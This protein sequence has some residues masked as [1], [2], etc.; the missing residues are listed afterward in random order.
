MSRPTETQQRRRR[1]RRDA[2]LR[3]ACVVT[4]VIAGIAAALPTGFALDPLIALGVAAIAA[5]SASFLPVT[6]ARV[7]ALAAVGLLAA[8]VT[9]LRLDRAPP[10]DLSSQL[11]DVH[12]D[13]IVTVRGRVTPNPAP[14]AFEPG[15]LDGFLFGTQ[16]QSFEL[17]A[18]GL[19]TDR[20]DR[21]SRGR[22]RITVELDADRLPA[23]GERIEATGRYVP[24][25]EPAN[26]GQRDLGAQQRGR[27]FAGTLASSSDLITPRPTD[28]AASRAGR[29]VAGFIEMARERVRG[30]L[31]GE[32]VESAAPGR[33]ALAA[34]VLGE[35]SAEL[36]E[37]RTAFAES[38]VAH[39]LA[40]SGFHLAALAWA[41]LGVLRLT[42]DLGRAAPL[43]TAAL[44]AGYLLIVPANAPI[45]RAGIVTIT[46]LLADA[47]GR[48]YDALTLLL[49][50]AAGIALWRPWEILTLGY[51]LTFLV[52]AALIVWATSSP[53]AV[54]A[55]RDSDH[56]AR[57][58]WLQLARSLRRASE[59]C[60]VAWLVAASLVVLHI[61][62]LNPL[63]P[64][65]ALVV[66]PIAGAA[67]A[68]GFAA[69]LIG[70]ALP[71][72]GDA[73]ASIAGSAGAVTL[74]TVDLAGSLGT[75]ASVGSIGLP[76][77]ATA[78][79][80]MFTALVARRWSQ[81]VSLVALAALVTL[82][83]VA[84]EHGR[85][86]R[87]SLRMD[88]L[89]VG[90][91]TSV[92]LRSGN[93][94]LLWDCGS[95]RP[96][97][98]RWIVPRAAREFGSPVITTAVLTHANVDHFAGL[99]QAAPQIGLERLICSPHTLA[100]LRASSSGRVLLDELD[101]IG[102]E[103]ET[104]V[105][106]DLITLGDARGDVLWPPAD[107]P[108]RT[109]AAN[110]RSLVVR[111]EVPTSAGVRT[112]LMTGDIQQAAMANL[113][114]RGAKLEA[115]VL[116]LPHHGSYHA[117][118]DAFV[119]AVSPR[120]VAQSTGPRRLDL[121]GWRDDIEA[122][123]GDASRA[124]LVT[125]RDGAVTVDIDRDGSIRARGYRG[126]SGGAAR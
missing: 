93:D 42:A 46:L 82:L 2:R 60:V 88:M 89:A 126:R 68:A 101:A 49:W 111:F 45:V 17:A 62:A 20:G 19:V 70:L 31:L 26:P 109:L 7:A 44:I 97:V 86:E 67:T 123:D 105:A 113:F 116:E 107:L 74:T 69:G 106:G 3:V 23:V 1:V 25:S 108:S 78:T 41:A 100:A 13:A 66:T 22:L 36:D 29:R 57:P 98:G 16:T 11:A 30:T 35:R 64:L 92:L 27:R 125:A 79:L 10:N 43:I 117:A 72:L 85:G 94:R 32:P 63:A 18:D 50:T 53:L 90:D 103:I 39:L 12:D 33:V 73:I 84:V 5:V 9:D 102:V 120:V 87:A 51:Q 95:L 115:D 38:G 83:G 118:A 71:T 6:A 104:V 119:D 59:A 58:L 4:A 114:A 76:L 24:R 96:G 54:S 21:S 81:A 47:S 28:T 80:V 65:T 124:W 112:V 37:T 122:F 121:P 34:L 75:R 55:E 40:L 48:R 61:G 99:P 52:T 91:G 14:P 15:P 8:A 77:A 110:D 56:A